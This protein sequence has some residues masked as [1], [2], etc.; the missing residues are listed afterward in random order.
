MA[1]VPQ[2]ILS[3]QG[4]CQKS[5]PLHNNSNSNIF[6]ASK[7]HVLFTMNRTSQLLH[8]SDRASFPCPF[9]GLR[10]A[11]LPTVFTTTC[12]FGSIACSRARGGGAKVHPSLTRQNPRKRAECAPLRLANRLGGIRTHPSC[13][14]QGILAQRTRSSCLMLRSRRPRAPDSSQ[15]MARKSTSSAQY[16]PGSLAV[17]GIGNPWLNEHNKTYPKRVHPGHA[18]TSA[19]RTGQPMSFIAQ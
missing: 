7:G 15:G 18:S 6:N 10:H 12:Y 11:R 16:N 1:A 2:W 13:S 4:I 17:C 8:S 14:W 5:G 3:A 9:P 19:Q